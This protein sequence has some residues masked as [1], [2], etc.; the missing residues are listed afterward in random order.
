[1]THDVFEKTDFEVNVFRPLIRSFHD[2]FLE[3]RDKKVMQ[4]TQEM[5]DNYLKG[6]QE[7]Q[8]QETKVADGKH[9]FYS[10]VGKREIEVV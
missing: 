4:V 7:C 9:I 1:M 6:M 2:Y 3:N 10:I 8:R 5:M